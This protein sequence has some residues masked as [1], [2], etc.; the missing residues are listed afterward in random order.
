M[1]SAVKPENNSIGRLPTTPNNENNMAV[2]QNTS[3]RC[4]GPWLWSHSLVCFTQENYW[5]EQSLTVSLQYWKNKI[6]I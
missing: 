2:L 1:E 4:T 5:G 3:D 6:V